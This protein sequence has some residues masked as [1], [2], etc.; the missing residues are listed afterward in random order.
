MAVK[1][2]TL[3]SVYKAS[4]DAIAAHANEYC[5]LEFTG[6]EDRDYMIREDCAAEGWVE[7]D[8]KEGATHAVVR[9]GKE[10]GK[11]GSYAYRGGFNGRMFSIPREKDTEIPIEFL[12]T[13]L[14][15]QLQGF[16][17]NPLTELKEGAPSEDR[18]EVAGVPISV[19][20]YLKKA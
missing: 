9:I 4:N 19:I 13:I 14:D 2:L 11:A 7:K 12:N 5:G 3:D 6:E 16:V 15:S 8:P 18:V 20:K 10:P 17:I 1:K